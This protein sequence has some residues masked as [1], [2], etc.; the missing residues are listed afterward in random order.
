MRLK[1]EPGHEAKIIILTSAFFFLVG[2]QGIRSSIFLMRDLEAPADFGFFVLVSVGVAPTLVV[3]SVAVWPS[4][5]S[6]SPVGCYS[7]HLQHSDFVCP[8][9]SLPRPPAQYFVVI[10]VTELIITWFWTH[11]QVGAY[12]LSW[13]LSN[14]SIIIVASP[15]L[16][17]VAQKKIRGACRGRGYI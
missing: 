5:S 6:C 7:Q 14:V 16:F 10:W 15:N 9:S 1:I 13:T 8:T 3:S 17:N 11:V 12:S 4:P 2:G